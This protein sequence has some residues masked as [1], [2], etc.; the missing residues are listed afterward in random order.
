MTAPTSQDVL[1]FWFNELGKSHDY[2]PA[3]AKRWFATDAALD[4]QIEERFVERVHAA[5]RGELDAWADEPAS[6]LA[7]LV[8]LDQFT[9]NIFRGDAAMYQ[10]DAKA[11]ALAETALKRGYD[12]RVHPVQAVFL[13]LPLEHA[14]DLE[15]QEL[16]VVLF[17]ALV[18]RVAPEYRAKYEGFLDYAY[19]HHDVIARFGRFPHRNALLGREDSEAERAYLS[20]GAGF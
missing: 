15:Q 3:L 9:R 4:Q 20:T 13:Y 2:D 7:L 10:Y 19:A 11:L 16:A 12:F 5:G 17:R 6:C 1:N 14:E 8:L 18:S